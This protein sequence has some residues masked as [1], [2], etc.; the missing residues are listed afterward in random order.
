M[1]ISAGSAGSARPSANTATDTTTG[2]PLVLV[3][4]LS[5]S[6]TMIYSAY[7]PAA[8]DGRAAL[9][10]LQIALQ[11]MKKA[12]VKS[13][14][15]HADTSAAKIDNRHAAAVIV[16]VHATADGPDGTIKI[17]LPLTGK[18]A[19]AEKTHAAAVKSAAALV[20]RAVPAA[21]VRLSEYNSAAR[22]ATLDAARAALV[23]KITAAVND[24]AAAG[25]RTAPRAKKEP[26]TAAA[27]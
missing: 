9:V 5:N 16:S 19:T 27:K 13:A 23:E 25:V 17:G 1:A 20:G 12:A 11:N 24:A 22:A 10:V 7:Q 21:A 18:N 8:L 14:K 26:A 15:R 2:A 4:Y 3:R 6:A